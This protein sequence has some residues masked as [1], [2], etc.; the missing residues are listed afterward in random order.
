[1]FEKNVSKKDGNCVHSIPTGGGERKG[2]Q[3]EVKEDD[4]NLKYGQLNNSD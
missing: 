3:E 4:I 2:F 1:M